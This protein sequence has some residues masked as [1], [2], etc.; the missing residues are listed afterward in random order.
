MTLVER[1]LWSP[2]Q[3]AADLAESKALFRRE[4]LEEPLEAY[5]EAFDL[6]RDSVENLIEE[7]VDLSLLEE[8]AP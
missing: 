1:T 6:V 8:K 7:T 5:S 3:F 4:R 2:E